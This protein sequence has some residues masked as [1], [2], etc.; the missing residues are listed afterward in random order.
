MIACG[1]ATV[2]KDSLPQHKDDHAMK[3]RNIILVFLAVNFAWIAGLCAGNA[4]VNKKN[5]RLVAITFDDL[6]SGLGL[7]SKTTDYADHAA[8]GAY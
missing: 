2:F 1:H 5:N 6:R 3:N 8:R 7:K 4:P